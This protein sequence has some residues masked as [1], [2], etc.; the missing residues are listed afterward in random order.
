[1]DRV[2]QRCASKKQKCRVRPGDVALGGAAGRAVRAGMGRD[3]L[4]LK[5]RAKSGGDTTALC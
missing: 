5:T 3:F 1:M 2:A 4:R